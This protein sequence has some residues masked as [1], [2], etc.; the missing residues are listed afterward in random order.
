MQTKCEAYKFSWEEVQCPA[1]RFR[2][3]A[4]SLYLTFK[5]C[6]LAFLAVLCHLPSVVCFFH[7]SNIP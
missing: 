3:L 7:H 2:Q 1:F 4:L 6:I 5:I